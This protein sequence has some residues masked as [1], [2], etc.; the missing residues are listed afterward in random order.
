MAVTVTRAY[1]VEG[2]SCEHCRASVDEHISAVEGVENVAVDLASGLVEVSGSGFDDAA[3]KGAV[4]AA[5]YRLDE[6][7]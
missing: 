3:V 6:V 1:S 2:M 4:E 5:G 7:R